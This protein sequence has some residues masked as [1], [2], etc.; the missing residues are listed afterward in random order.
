[1]INASEEELNDFLKDCYV[2]KIK[3]RETLNRVGEVPNE[4]YFIRKGL[5]RCLLV[6]RNGTEHTVGFTMENRFVTDYSNYLQR[7]P[8]VFSLEAIED[9]EVVVMP[10]ESINRGYKNMK[11]GDNWVE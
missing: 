2:K 3:R 9:L 1:M 10:R 6:D 4:I 8:S 11:E 5:L 7:K